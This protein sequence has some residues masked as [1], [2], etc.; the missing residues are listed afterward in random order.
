MIR[1]FQILL[2]VALGLLCSAQLIAYPTGINVLCVGIVLGTCLAVGIIT[3]RSENF[4]SVPISTLQVTTFTLSNFFVPLL[5]TTLEGNPLVY[6]LKLPVQA[7]GLSALAALTL[8]LT[9]AIYRRLSTARKLRDLASTRVAGPIGLFRAPTTLQLWLMGGIG[10]AAAI[11]SALFFRRDMIDTSGVLQ[12]LLQG[13]IP[14]SYAPFLIPLACYFW[15][16]PKPTKFTWFAFGLYFVFI[17]G[18]SMAL[19]A[20][21]AFAI[22]LATMVGC[23]ILAML[24]NKLRINFFSLRSAAFALV[25]FLVIVPSLGD[26]AT[27]MRVARSDRS[28]LAATEMIGRSVELFF[29]KQRLEEYRNLYQTTRGALRAGEWDE[30]YIKNEFLQRF[31]F[32]KFADNSLFYTQNFGPSERQRLAE[33]A[34]NRIYAQIPSPVLRAL[35][36][37][38]NKWNSLTLSFGDFLYY[39]RTGFD[40]A[41]FRTGSFIGIDRA[42]FGMGFLGV[43]AALAFLIFLIMDSF[44]YRSTVTNGS[45]KSIDVR[46]SPMILMFLFT[47]AFYFNNEA[48]ASMLS[49]LLRMLPQTVVIYLLL[50]YGTA[51][52]NLLRPAPSRARSSIRRDSLTLPPA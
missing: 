7:F 1:Q 40:Y 45:Q 38:Y 29:D 25:A 41:G 21:G 51:I 17:A 28:K 37:R 4:A 3:F 35:G 50:F 49:G 6:N 39:A 47:F 24:T 34:V 27:A 2:L 8:A 16:A 43:F 12:Q 11:A 48:L 42:I 13:F 10:A 14:F 23:I 19:N 9:H 5:G 31:A 26:I 52:V 33:F 32:L 20:R 44:S 36:I 18:I 30:R 46:I 22:P 15:P